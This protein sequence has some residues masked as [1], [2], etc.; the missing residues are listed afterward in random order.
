MTTEYQRTD[1]A[2]AALTEMQRQVT[3]ESAT[4]PAFRNEFWNN[5]TPGLYVDIVSGQPLFSSNDKYDSGC[6][7]PSFVK[8]LDDE[9]ITEHVDSSYGMRRT[10][11]RSEGADSHLG[12]VF[13]DGPADRGGL[14]YCINSA[15]LR[16]IPAD[17]LEIEGYGEYLAEFE[18]EGEH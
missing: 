14:R 11:V 7:W 4:E 1:D 16:F 9:V 13:T 6:G 10:E 15:A 8:P 12:H 17:E 5:H 2:V 3:Q 18:Q